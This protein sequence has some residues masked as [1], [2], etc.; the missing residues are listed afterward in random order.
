MDR[1][2]SWRG[3]KHGVL[4]GFKGTLL[5]QVDLRQGACEVERNLPVIF[6]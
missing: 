1:S 2:G 3:L 6:I 4:F 5:K